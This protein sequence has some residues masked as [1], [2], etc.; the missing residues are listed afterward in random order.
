MILEGSIWTPYS[1]AVEE[2]KEILDVPLEKLRRRM[3][4]A[5]MKGYESGLE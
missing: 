4:E 3:K 5:T 2:I 1:E